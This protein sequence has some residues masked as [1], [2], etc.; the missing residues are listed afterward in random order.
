MSCRVSEREQ[1][2]YKVFGGIGRRPSLVHRRQGN[3]Q[4]TVVQE[5]PPYVIC[6][7]ADTIISG[8][9]FCHF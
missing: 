8:T 9:T 3:E 6:C 4:C 2:P 5:C 7:P 1:M